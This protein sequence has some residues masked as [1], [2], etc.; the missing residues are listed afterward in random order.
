MLMHDRGFPGLFGLGLA[1]KLVIFHETGTK[2]LYNGSIA[3]PFNPSKLSTSCAIDWQTITFGA[4]TR[5]RAYAIQYTGDGASP[6]TLSF[7]LNFDGYEGEPGSFTTGMLGT[8]SAPNPTA[9]HIFTPPSAVSVLPMVERIMQLQ[10]ITIELHR[11]PLCEVWW[12]QI[13]LIEGP[14]TSLTQDF[15]RFL[16]D[17]TPVRANLGLTFTDASLTYT[18]ELCS[19]D[20]EKTYTVRLGDTLQAISARQ[21][22]SPA[23]WRRIAEAN[24]IDDPRR[25]V[26]GTILAIPALR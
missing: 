6:A 13:R 16:P 11:P 17:G 24:A 25:L 18:G 22:G 14:L 2:R 1:S 5:Q 12:G 23:H 8:L 7:D 15:T 10:Q 21:Y 26:P 4:T 9:M 19:A 3:V 20:V